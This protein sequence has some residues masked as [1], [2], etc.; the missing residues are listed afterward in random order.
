MLWSRR[1]VLLSQR[2]PATARSTTQPRRFPMRSRVPRSTPRGRGA[3]S[4]QGRA[5]AAG[6]ACTPDR[7]RIEASGATRAFESPSCGV[8]A[9][10]AVC[11]PPHLRTPQSPHPPF[12]IGRGVRGS[13]TVFAIRDAPRTYNPSA[14]ICSP[15]LAQGARRADTTTKRR[16]IALPPWPSGDAT[17]ASR[18]GASWNPSEG[19]GRIVRRAAAATPARREWRWQANWST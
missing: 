10:C 4:S 6:L 8:R 7:H 3:G 11:A 17:H 1:A 13:F 12:A 14:D 19:R 2:G 16:R 9:G 15:G 5:R 18:V